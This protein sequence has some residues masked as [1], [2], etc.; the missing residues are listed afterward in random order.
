[1]DQIRSRPRKIDGPRRRDP[2]ASRQKILEAGMRHFARAGLDG[3][4]V[5]DIIRDAQF[6]HRMLY[7]Y[8]KSKE[9]LYEA[10]LEFAYRQIREAE[11]ELHMENLD[12]VEGVSL[13]VSFTFDYYVKNPEFMALLSQENLNGGRYVRRS[14]HLRD[15]Q[16]PLI[17][18]LEDLLQRGHRTG[19]FARAMDPIQ[20]YIDIAGLCYFGIVNRHTLSAIFDASIAEDPYL[21]ARKTHVVDFIISALT[22]RR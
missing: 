9:E 17:S 1:V 6:S 21:V 11:R 8:F 12:P 13:L 18:S 14:G 2:V 7:H 16:Q 19:V 5:T 15:I 10:T 22:A 20:L 3:A 4:R